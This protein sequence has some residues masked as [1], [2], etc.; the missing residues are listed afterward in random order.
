[1]WSAIFLHKKVV[2]L[3]IYNLI[4]NFAELL[5]DLYFMGPNVY[6]I[7]VQLS[8]IFILVVKKTYQILVFLK[9]GLKNGNLK[10]VPADFAKHSCLDSALQTLSL[11]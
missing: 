11:Q 1:M 2:T 10:I 4:F 3:T 9:T 7:M 8:G 5:L 6:A